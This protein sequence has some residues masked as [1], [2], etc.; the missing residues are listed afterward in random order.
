M[1]AYD[2]ID[3]T[4]IIKIQNK[5]IDTNYII[6]I[7][8]YYYDK[9][10]YFEKKFE[11]EEIANNNVSYD[12]RYYNF[13]KLG[14][15]FSFE[16]QDKDKRNLSYNQKHFDFLLKEIQ[17]NPDLIELIRFKY[18][19]NYIPDYKNNGIKRDSITYYITIYFPNPINDEFEI[20][21]F[22]KDEEKIEFEKDRAFIEQITNELPDKLDFYVNKK[23]LITQIICFS[24][25]YILASF[26]LILLLILKVNIPVIFYNQNTFLLFQLCSSFIIG[27]LSM[28]FI[29]NN[30]YKAFYYFQY[31]FKDD[32]SDYEKRNYEKTNEIYFGNS[33]KKEARETIKFL[34]NFSKKSL[35]YE[36]VSLVLI[37]I[38]MIFVL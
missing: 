21:M 38:I 22:I 2:K 18:D 5:I 13:Y 24:I 36:L 8:N 9:F 16:I 15:S 27:N 7:F 20:N 35:I 23:T 6:K 10:N 1:I 32:A 33:E 12:E 30:T 26:I 17:N 29:V 14:H 28:Y 19:L 31:S 34:F 3:D 25:G 4:T 11:E 37:Y